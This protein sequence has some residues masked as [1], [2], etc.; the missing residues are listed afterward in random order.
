MNTEIGDTA[1]IKDIGVVNISSNKDNSVKLYLNNGET[2]VNPEIT[3]FEET[4]KSKNSCDVDQGKANENGIAGQN[5]QS[6]S[7]DTK[8]QKPKI[9]FNI[10][11]IGGLTNNRE[12]FKQGIEKVA[13]IS[14][15]IDITI[16]SEKDLDKDYDAK[17]IM[18]DSK[19]IGH[20][21]QKFTLEKGK[22]EFVFKDVTYFGEEPAGFNIAP[23]TF[24][25]QLKLDIIGL[26][27][28]SNNNTVLKI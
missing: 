16:S 13:K 14:F 24:T 12:R 8:T 11:S 3:T 22:K 7:G 23:K 10:T 18:Y 21:V 5:N 9:T 15:G 27:S 20:E 26:Y 17:L 6:P 1:Q 25:Y 4:I 28:V 19:M 2:S